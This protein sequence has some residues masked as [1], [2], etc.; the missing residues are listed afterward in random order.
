MGRCWSV[1]A[2]ADAGCVAG[3]DVVAV[4]LVGEVDALR[5][6]PDAQEH[7]DCSRTRPCPRPSRRVSTAAIVESSRVSW[8]E[9][10]NEGRFVTILLKWTS[11]AVCPHFMRERFPCTRMNP[12][13]SKNRCSRVEAKMRAKPSELAFLD[14]GLDELGAY[15]PPAAGF[16]H[17]QALDLRRLARNQLQG[18]AVADH[19]LGLEPPAP[20]R[21]RSPAG[22][23]K[24]RRET[25]TACG[26]TRHDG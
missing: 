21:R 22:A 10:Q 20:G 24:G 13:R 15:P 4:G 11:D 18:L 12:S 17:R 8:F 19:G 14:G 9:L 3:A 25:G 7:Q 5:A 2:G 16:V 6:N 1:G 23:R 26:S